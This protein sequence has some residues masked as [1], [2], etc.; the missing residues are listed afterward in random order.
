M[1][2]ACSSLV[3]ALREARQRDY[4]R[5]VEE[6]ASLL[7][8]G[9]LKVLDLAPITVQVLAVRPS[10]SESELHGLYTREEGRPTRIQLWMRTAH[11]RCRWCSSMAT[12]SP[13]TSSWSR[14]P[15]P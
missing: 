12:S 14:M 8:Q 5:E 3:D 9:I 7:A 2:S 1:R 10:S 6:A 4:R 13:P 11:H 15:A